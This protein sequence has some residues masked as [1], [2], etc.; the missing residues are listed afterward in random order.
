[1]GHL[2]TTSLVRTIREMFTGDLVDAL[3]E[4]GARAYDVV[5]EPRGPDCQRECTAI[6]EPVTRR[7]DWFT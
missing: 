2:T 3:K 6:L 5:A 4:I 1:V 7:H